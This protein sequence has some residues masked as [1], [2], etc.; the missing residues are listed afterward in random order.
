M[1]NFPE[2][3]SA[4]GC[5]ELR[6]AAKKLTLSRSIKRPTF[7]YPCPCLHKVLFLFLHYFK[8]FII[9]VV[10]MF[11]YVVQFTHSGVHVVG[12]VIT[13]V[14]KITSDGKNKNS[15]LS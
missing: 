9:E 1:S 12:T 10:L 8:T 4:L 15:I 14:S 7:S 11:Y 13:E 5:L 3:E 2:P 6:L